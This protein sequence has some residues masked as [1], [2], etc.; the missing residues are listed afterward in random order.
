MDHFLILAFFLTCNLVV[1]NCADD[2]TVASSEKDPEANA[3]P[4]HL[5]LNETSNFWRRTDRVCGKRLIRDVLSSRLRIIGGR[6]S[7]RGSWPWQVLIFN[8]LHEPFCGGTLIHPEFVLTAAHC[9]RQRLYVRAGEHDLLTDEGTEQEIR[10]A[11]VYTHPDY[12]V[13]TVDNDMALLRLRKPFRMT[14]YVS[15]ACLPSAKTYMDV[16]SMGT[17]LGWG[18][19]DNK[20]PF[21]TDVLHEAQVPIASVHSCKSVYEDYF[22]SN[23]MVCAGYKRGKVDSC[24]GDSGGPL[25]F[26]KNG[27]WFIY[28]ITSFGEGCGRKGKYGIYAKVPNFV[29]WIR[30]TI[31]R[32]EKRRLRR[33]LRTALLMG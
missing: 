11:Q 25:L 20:E 5:L 8:K 3:M 13:E 16:D 28:G 6:E 15:V 2:T 1:I 31:R 7:R 19:R 9:V 23:N 14:K 26:E 22:I 29:K 12:D 4:F 21:G 27:R 18:K 10:V 32:H 24:A 30:K 33:K 17:I